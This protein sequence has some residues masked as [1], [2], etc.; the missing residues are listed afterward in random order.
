M[1]MYQLVLIVLDIANCPYRS[2]KGILF[3]CACFDTKIID[4][5][6]R[7]FHCPGSISLVLIIIYRHEVHPHRGFSRLVP[8]I[9]GIHWRH[10]IKGNALSTFFHP[11]LTTIVS[12]SSFYCIQ[13][14]CLASQDYTAGHAQHDA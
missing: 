8:L 3:D 9:V 12:N 11:S 10:P 2:V 13:D 6:R 4:D 14:E 1:D 5:I 7:N